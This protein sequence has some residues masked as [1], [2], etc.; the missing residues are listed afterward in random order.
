MILFKDLFGLNHVAVDACLLAP[1]QFNQR[2]QIVADHIGFRAVLPHHAKLF[3]FGQSFFLAFM[4]HLR[5][6]DLAFVLFELFVC[7]SEFF[8]NRLNLFIQVVVALALFH[9]ALYSAANTLFCL[10]NIHFL[11]QNGKKKFEPFA[12]TALVE[13]Q[14]FALGRND[15][16]LG[17]RIS[18][19][20]RII[21]R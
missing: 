21:N 16:G 17:D 12:D 5:L 10:L 18:K 15:Q 20:R 7:F 19:L 1:R 9:R 11:F 6:F 8:L 2:I 13:Q 4:A 3:E 14:L